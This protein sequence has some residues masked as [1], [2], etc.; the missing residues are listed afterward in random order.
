MI[1]SVSTAVLPLLFLTFFVFKFFV[2]F[3]LSICTVL[4]AGKVSITEFSLSLS[5][6]CVS[7]YKGILSFFFVSHL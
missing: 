1:L 7:V 3:F 2:L 4:S 5:L 6:M